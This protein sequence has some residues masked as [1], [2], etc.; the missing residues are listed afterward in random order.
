MFG[1][2]PMGGRHELNVTTSVALCGVCRSA[3]ATRSSFGRVRRQAAARLPHGGRSLRAV[4]QVVQPWMTGMAR[5]RPIRSTSTWRCKTQQWGHAGPHSASA[6]VC[7]RALHK[8][9]SEEELVMGA[10][11]CSLAPDCISALLQ[12][13][14]RPVHPAGTPCP[15]PA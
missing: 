1:L 8:S 2:W 3:W 15:R 7:G 9:D 13:P 14:P 10:L 12:P 11:M 4:G 5:H 6:V